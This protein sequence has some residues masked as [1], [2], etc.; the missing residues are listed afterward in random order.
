MK[1]TAQQSAQIDAI[2]QAAFGPGKEVRSFAFREGVHDGLI[3]KFTGQPVTQ[4]PRRQTGYAHDDAYEF[5]LHR[6]DVM[7]RMGDLATGP[8]TADDELPPPMAAPILT[9]AQALAAW[10][11]Q[12]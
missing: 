3:A 2:L 4:M 7:W 8:T 10:E 11:A 5:G 9:A 6:A 12:A 1:L